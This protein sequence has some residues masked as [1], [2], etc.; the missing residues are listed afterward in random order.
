MEVIYT[1]DA[2]V[3]TGTFNF[4]VTTSGDNYPA[5][6]NQISVSTSG[7][8]LTASS[9]VVRRQRDLYHHRRA[10]GGPHLGRDHPLRW[11][12]NAT[13]GTETISFYNGSAGYSVTYTPSGGSAT[14]DT[15]TAGDVNRGERNL[16]TRDCSRE[17]RHAH[18][19]R[20]GDQPG[21]QRRPRSPTTSRCTAG[22][23]T[24]ETSTSVT[25][26]N[27]VT[28]VS[29]VPS[30]SLAG[31]TTNY[32]V[33]FRASDAVSVGGDIDLSELAG[34]TNFTGCHGR[35]RERPDARVELRRHGKLLD[36]R[37][38]S[39]PTARRH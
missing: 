35:R 38:R 23:G 2:P 10:G 30:N 13:V 18:H 25:F 6:S 15:V 31:A 29:V 34:P 21:V 17:R 32:T 8:T 24:P 3:T 12:A 37:Y 39:D 14:A 33:G 16:D 22:N 28:S 7:S 11:C 4:T 20:R 27:S 36:E 19:H 9:L 1:A 26:G 5:I